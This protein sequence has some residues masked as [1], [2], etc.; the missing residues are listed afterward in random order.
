MNEVEKLK[1]ELYAQIRTLAKGHNNLKDEVE[2]LHG[3]VGDLLSV[4][5][6]QRKTINM[7]NRTIS[8][9]HN[10]IHS[11]TEEDLEESGE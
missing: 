7:M 10:I 9:H 5:E 6:L 2:E 11:W 4:C 8:I 3:I 1:Q